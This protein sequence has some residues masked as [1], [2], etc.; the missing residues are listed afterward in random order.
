MSLVVSQKVGCPQKYPKFDVLISSRVIVMIVA[1]VVAIG[2]TKLIII[3]QRAL[4]VLAS[5]HTCP[6]FYYVLL[7]THSSACMKQR[8]L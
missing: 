6:H 2:A 3:T 7:A 4:L 5:E 1:I 8:P